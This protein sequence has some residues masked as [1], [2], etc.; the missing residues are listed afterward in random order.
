MIGLIVTIYFCS[1][2]W[3]W[4]DPDYCQINACDAVESMQ[5]ALGAQLTILNNSENDLRYEIVKLERRV[6]SLEQPED[7]WHD[8]VQGPCKCKPETKSVSCWNKH[9]MALPLGQVIPQDLQT[10]DLGV[11]FLTTLNKDSFKHLPRLSQLDLFN[12]KINHLPDKIFEQL[13]EIQYLTVHKNFLQ[14]VS[15]GIFTDLK[16]LRTLD[17]SYNKLNSLPSRLFSGNPNLVV[18]YLSGNMVKILPV[19][20]FNNLQHLED[21]DLSSNSMEAIHETIFH[22]LWKVK[23]LNLAENKIENLH[24]DT[25]RD[26]ESLENLNLRRNHLVVISPVLLSNLVNLA[27]LELSS[28]KIVKISEGVFD[29]GSLKEL[30]LQQNYMY[31]L[32]ENLFLQTRR[33][34]KLVLFSNTFV[35]LRENSFRG[36][37]NLTSLVLNNNLLKRLHPKIFSHVPNLEKLRLDS[38]SFLYLPM[39][40]LDYLQKLTAIKLTKNPWHCDCNTLYL[41]TWINENSN[42]LWDSQP[43]C[44]GP[45]ELGGAEIRSMNFDSLCHGQWA[46]MIN[47]SARIPV[48]PSTLTPHP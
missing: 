23:R 24:L 4:I 5:R 3:A 6:R 46:S 39:K 10:L 9:V 31:E 13:W 7:R 19:G 45:G 34:E 32:P 27:V 14:E 28:N 25:F 42:K 47:L 40:S 20:L 38:N 43:T 26:L 36:L 35:E 29:L 37:S 18:L 30:H 15:E 17:L 8:C 21:L 44:K 16:N 41:S 12:N 1:A 48:R 11:N 33:L 22:G 2:T